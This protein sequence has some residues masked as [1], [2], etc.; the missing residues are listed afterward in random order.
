MTVL[1]WEDTLSK[2][3]GPGILVGGFNPKAQ[4]GVGARDHGGQTLGQLLAGLTGP[5]AASDAER[6]RGSGLC[7]QIIEV[8]SSRV[9]TRRRSRAA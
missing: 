1:R 5:S 7:T 2:V 8:L 9:A 3:A 6:D 4:H